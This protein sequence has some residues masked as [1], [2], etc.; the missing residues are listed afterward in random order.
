MCCYTP[1][2]SETPPY[3]LIIEKSHRLFWEIAG[4]HTCYPLCREIVKQ[5]YGHQ[6]Y[7]Y[8]YQVIVLNSGVEG[9]LRVSVITCGNRG[10]AFGSLLFV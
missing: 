8:M 4:P 3:C 5:Q 10:G 7:N 9:S 6:M 2:A 1:Q